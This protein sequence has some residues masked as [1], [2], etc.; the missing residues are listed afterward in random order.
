MKSIENTE[1][2]IN[3]IIQEKL[4]YGIRK[5]ILEDRKNKLLKSFEYNSLNNNEK[6]KLLNNRYKLWFDEI[7]T[8]FLSYKSI[9]ALYPSTKNFCKIHTKR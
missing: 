1:N 6:K 3:K 9:I 7:S 2:E 5:M 4:F 8:F